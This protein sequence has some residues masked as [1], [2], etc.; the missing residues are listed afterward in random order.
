MIPNPG[1]SEAISHGC[2]CAVMDNRYG[3]GIPYPGSDKPSFWI[4]EDCP[5]HG[6][7]TASQE[8]PE[9]A[10]GSEEARP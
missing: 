4:S 2:R 8:R 6:A 5:L 3:A 9:T 10:R 1:S 7:G